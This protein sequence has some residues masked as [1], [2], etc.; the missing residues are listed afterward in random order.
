MLQKMWQTGSYTELPVNVRNL[1]LCS[2]SVLLG[3][4]SVLPM[5]LVFLFR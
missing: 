1:K 3:W 2:S 4:V 5:I